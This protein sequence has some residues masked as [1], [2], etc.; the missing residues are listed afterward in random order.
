MLPSERFIAP[1]G[2]LLLHT[3]LLSSIVCHRPALLNFRLAFVDVEWAIAGVA[4]LAYLRTV[5]CDPGF[6]RQPSAK[7]GRPLPASTGTAGWFTSS[8]C[9]WLVLLQRVLGAHKTATTNH[10]DGSIDTREIRELQPL[11]WSAL[12]AVELSDVDADPGE[13]IIDASDLESAA[14]IGSFQ[15]QNVDS[16][17]QNVDSTGS[18]NGVGI[19]EG[20][21]GSSSTSSASATRSSHPVNVDSAGVGA[22]L[23]WGHSDPTLQAHRIVM[24]SGHRLRYCPVCM[25]HQPLRTKHCR[26]CGHCVRTH[27]HH[28]PWIGTCVG[29]GNHL[30]FF[31]FLLA[32]SIELMVFSL[33]GFLEL[34]EDGFDIAKWIRNTPLLVLGLLVMAMLLVMTTCLLVFHTYL[35]LFNVTTWEHIS[36][37]HV[38]YLRSVPPED[39]SPFS[40]SLLSNL[41]LFCCPPWCL[42]CGCQPT[43]FIWTEDGWA[44]WE[45]FPPQSGSR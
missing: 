44:V 17:F 43:S 39:G 15:F 42:T 31:F 27:D 24:Q 10:T 4:L 36:W 6:L 32:Q 21:A 19:G 35:A 28:C 18:S 14:T 13:E 34:L 30:F 45:L 8:G 40:V 16:T 26:E 29:E 11:G 1:V 22:S 41:A 5:L 25:M 7:L 2:V 37:H 3:S 9:C 38:S 23:A 12:D 20:T 33:E